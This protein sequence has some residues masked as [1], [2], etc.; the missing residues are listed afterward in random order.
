MVSSAQGVSP[1]DTPTD[2]DCHE[3]LLCLGLPQAIAAWDR[4][5]TP[6]PNDRER[7]R[8]LQ[9]LHNWHTLTLWDTGSW[10]LYMPG[11]PFDVHFLYYRREHDVRASMPSFVARTPAPLLDVPPLGGT[12]QVAATQVGGTILQASQGPMGGGS[13]AQNVSSSATQQGLEPVQSPPPHDAIMAEPSGT[14]PQGPDAEPMDTD[15][16]MS[17][18][19]GEINISPAE[20]PLPP[21]PEPSATVVGVDATA[22]PPTSQRRAT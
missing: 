2:N 18:G 21:S 10:F 13:G 7:W 1:C 15:L 4:W 17:G 9:G 22:R 3:R 20:V 8:V 12:V 5:Y 6:S 16:P 11:M 14:T 19:S